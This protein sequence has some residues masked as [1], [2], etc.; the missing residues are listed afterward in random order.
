MKYV[1]PSPF[2]GGSCCK[3]LT[4]SSRNLAVT[5]NQVTNTTPSGY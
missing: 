1:Y 2:P 3:S 4:S 5:Y